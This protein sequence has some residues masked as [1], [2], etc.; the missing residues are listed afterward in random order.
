VPAENI[1]AVLIFFVLFCLAYYFGR[2]Q[3]QALRWL[4]TQ[5]NIP[6][7]DEQ[8][9][10][11]Q[12]KLRL[13]GCGLLVLLGSQVA[14]AYL[15]G[16]EDR[17]RD[18]AQH[19]QRQQQ[20][21]EPIALTPEQQALR[22]VYGIYWIAALVVLSAIVFLAAFD[23][24]AIRRYGRRHLKKIQ[25]ERRAMLEGQVARMRTERNGHGGA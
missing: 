15:F 4:H 9:A 11:R 21:G 18:L 1:F 14:G 22:T 10:R 19:V 5:P 23:I 7:E 2:Q 8:Y 25:D 24:W 20:A 16:L 3:M 6:S 12:I 17:I 13:I